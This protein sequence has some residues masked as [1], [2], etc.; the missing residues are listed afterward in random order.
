[1]KVAIFSGMSI[2]AVIEILL[3]PFCDRNPPPSLEQ[4][5]EFSRPELVPTKPVASKAINHFLLTTVN[6][7]FVLTQPFPQPGCS[8]FC[9]LMLLADQTAAELFVSSYQRGGRWVVKSQSKSGKKVG[10]NQ[11]AFSLLPVF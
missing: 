5:Q 4:S 3:F 8:H 11:E 2:I 9:K 1:M 7:E 6:Q 10:S